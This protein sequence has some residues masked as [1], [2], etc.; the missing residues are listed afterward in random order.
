M[1]ELHYLHF[2]ESFEDSWILGHHR[3]CEAFCGELFFRSLAVNQQQVEVYC[4]D[5][6]VAPNRGQPSTKWRDAGPYVSK[7][8][9]ELQLDPQYS[10]EGHLV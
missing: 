5:E 6:G 3:F 1:G 7:R 2:G 8:E 9:S 4:N 10:E